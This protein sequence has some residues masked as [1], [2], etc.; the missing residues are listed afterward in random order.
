MD[1]RTWTE[2]PVKGKQEE[3]A[4]EYG[5]KFKAR[6]TYHTWQGEEPMGQSMRCR[7]CTAASAWTEIKDL[8]WSLVPIKYIK[9][10]DHDLDIDFP[11]GVKAYPT[12]DA[13]SAGTGKD[14]PKNVWRDAFRGI[15]YG[16]D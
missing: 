16:I 10:I 3:S 12:R 7:N 14:G 5:T 15:S 2:N 8:G 13:G 4:P 6:R 9:F 1:L 11:C